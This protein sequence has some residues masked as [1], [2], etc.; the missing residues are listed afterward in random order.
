MTVPI[1]KKEKKQTTV[2]ETQSSNAIKEKREKDLKNLKNNPAIVI[3]I[4]A[5]IRGYRARQIT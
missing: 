3:K 5:M 2:V 1:R 4:Q